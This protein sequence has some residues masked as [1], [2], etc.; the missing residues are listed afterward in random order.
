MNEVRRERRLLL[1]HLD[2]GFDR[3]A[4]HGTNLAG[5]I[6]GLTARQ[7]AW[8]PG[9]GRHSIWEI[10]LHAAFWKHAIRGRLT[11]VPPEP[12]PHRGRDWP[13][14]PA[15]LDARAWRADVALL[16]E[17]HRELRAV[18]AA[19]PAARLGRKVGNRRWTAE[20]T[21]LG[22]ALHDVYHA[23]QIQ[24]IKRLMRR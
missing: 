5:S 6:R 14:L 8:R 9:R 21:I 13:A 15:R 16:A 20:G 1:E 3:A 2:H 23:G 18:V 4:W 10:V 22:M 11:G 7:A 24:L 17:Q 19:F 12:F